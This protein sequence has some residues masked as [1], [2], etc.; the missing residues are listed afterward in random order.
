MINIRDQIPF[1]P[2]GVELGMRSWIFTMSSWLPKIRVLPESIIT[3]LLLICTLVPSIFTFS[4][5]VC[6]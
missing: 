6:Q 5:L 2:I 3:A 4:S 1:D